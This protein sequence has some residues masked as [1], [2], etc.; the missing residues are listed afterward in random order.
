MQAV[1]KLSNTYGFLRIDD[2]IYIISLVYQALKY[3]TSNMKCSKK[4]QDKFESLQ[5]IYPEKLKLTEG[6]YITLY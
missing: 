4:F 5:S 1:E 2:Y 3:K 6:I